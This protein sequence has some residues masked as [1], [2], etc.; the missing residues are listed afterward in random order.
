[1]LEIGVGTTIDKLLQE[2]EKRGLAS[3]LVLPEDRHKTLWRVIKENSLS[4]AHLQKYITSTESRLFDGQILTSTSQEPFGNDLYDIKGVLLSESDHLTILS[5]L[6]LKFE[7]PTY[8]FESVIEL[9]TDAAGTPISDINKYI[10]S[11][12]KQWKEDISL[13][14][15]THSADGVFK[16]WLAVDSPNPT[17]IALVASQI[18][19]AYPALASIF[20]P[21]LR[22]NTN[23]IAGRSNSSVLALPISAE[24]RSMLFTGRKKELA[25]LAQNLRQFVGANIDGAKDVHILHDHVNF[26]LTSAT[27]QSGADIRSKKPAFKS[28]HIKNS[29]ESQLSRVVLLRR[30]MRYMAAGKILPGR[31]VHGNLLH[32]FCSRTEE[33]V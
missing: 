33:Q 27:Q 22:V 7:E 26:L 18:E 13:N 19:G 14:L 28:R 25:I 9:Q 17:K 3:P 21:S 29:S 30:H 23:S 11:F 4:L 2:C 24:H 1:M 32:E 10:R 16:H 15:T 20:G 12:T 8:R 6:H 31:T 5:N